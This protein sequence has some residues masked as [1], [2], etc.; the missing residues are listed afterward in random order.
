[1]F[2]QSRAVSIAMWLAAAVFAAV[3]AP[4]QAEEDV[5]VVLDASGSMW[6]ELD[7]APKIVT[8]RT[9]VGGLLDDLPADRR[10]G[11]VAY[12]HNRKGDCSDIEEIAP[13]GASR[14]AIRA[15]VDALNP[16]GKTPLSAS[17]KFAAEKLKYTENRATVILVSDGKETCNLDPCDVGAELEKT[18]VDFTAH[19]IGFDIA[20]EQD[21]AELRCLAES[22]GG[23]YFDAADAAGLSE[24][25]EETVAAPAEP[26][27]EAGF[28]L[29]ATELKGGPLIE[30]GLSWRV[31]QAGGGEV[32]FEADDAGPVRADLPPG[33]YDVFV[34]RASDGLK[35]E[36][37]GVELRPGA[38]KTVTVPLELS[39]EATIRVSPEGSAPVSSEVI[40]TWTGP[41]RQG[42]YV[43]I[44]EKGAPQNAYTDY[45][46]TR[47]GNPLK[48]RMPTEA[49]EYEA[50]Y[51]LGRPARVLASVPIDAVAV[52]ASLEAPESVPAGA[53]F[54]I[55]W[56]GPG[57]QDD[58]I[59][60]VKPDAKERDYTSYGYTREGNPVTITAPLEAGEYELRYLQA[61][62]K[63]IARRPISV[64]GVEAS[65]SG[66]ETAM[67]GTRHEISWTG[68]AGDR[69]WVTVTAPGARDNAYTDYA[70][71]RT[72]NPVTI[73]MPLEPGDYEIRYVQNGKKVIARRN[74]TVTA[75]EA[76]LDAPE[77]AEAGSTV[78]VAW[79]GPA[80]DRDWVTVTAPDAREN[81]YTD[82]EY[83]QKKGNPLDIDMPVEPGVYEFRYVL[84]GKKV[85]A[86]KSVTVTDATASLD[87]ATSVSAGADLS[88]AWTG[89]AYHRDYIT[90][91]EPDANDRAYKSYKY[92]RTGSPVVL[93]AP[94]EPGEY[95]LRYVLAGKRVIARRNITVTAGE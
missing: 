85:V 76:S 16:K 49:G 18:G 84:D 83:P 8:A 73:R 46:Y 95:E 27:R 87:A 74:V 41:D 28:D 35:G 17:V 14:A 64:A 47:Q 82:Y 65:V 10:L 29:R 1:M 92:A 32:L 61:G 20:A 51:V 94:A 55:S 22:T 43:T 58:W 33:V 70:Y 81:S 53:P 21:R 13:V 26:A 36:A 68:P 54:D 45:E 38:E 50:R 52:E 34:E 15:A 91:A 62:R 11:L 7:G 40:V 9:V 59:T 67:A 3:A 56:T 57:Y 12:G 79:T 37:R 77:T 60:I 5:I 69:D 86:R 89:P 63:I 39:F 93:K 71:M 88:V 30:G 75:A 80:E 78:K 48:L 6:G 44:A 24:A 25:L 4:A 72:G 23:R 66:P 90:I 2:A 31:Q 42:D 19:V